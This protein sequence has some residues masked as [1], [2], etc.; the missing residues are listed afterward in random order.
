[1]VKLARLDYGVPE[2]DL[3]IS[4]RRFPARP[5]DGVVLTV[6]GSPG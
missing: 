4:L 3:E 5:A 6:Q 1:V 2:Q